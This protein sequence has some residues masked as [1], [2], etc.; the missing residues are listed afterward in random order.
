MD[1]LSKRTDSLRI[2]YEPE[3][4]LRLTSEDR[5][6]IEVR[7][8]WASPMTNPGKYLALI[9]AKD[10]EIVMFTEPEKELSE[11][12]WEIVN[13]DLE[14]RYLNGF[15]LEI[16]EAKTVFGYTYWTVVTDRGKK[17]FV[18]M[19]LQENAQWMSPTHL[20]LNDVDGNRFEITDTNA[21]DPV[22]R[23]KLDLTV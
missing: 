19:S 13:R 6:W 21:M 12:N 8:V 3:G 20:I 9:D 15:V 5:S 1:A 22:S 2:F 23:K 10:N 18:T 11:E 4:R 16:I 14:R 7:P 17:D